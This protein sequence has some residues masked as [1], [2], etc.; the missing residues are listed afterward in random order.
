MSDIDDQIKSLTKDELLSLFELMRLKNVRWERDLYDV[1][2]MIRIAK[3]AE[4]KEN[5]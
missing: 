3:R 4:N 1:L 5:K 2:T